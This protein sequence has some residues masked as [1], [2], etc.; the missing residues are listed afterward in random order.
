M[1]AKFH[2]LAVHDSRLLLDVR[3]NR[4]LPLLRRSS[5]V[6]EDGVLALY[7][8]GF[9]L[10]HEPP[11]ARFRG[12]EGGLVGRWGLDQLVGA[13]VKGWRLLP[14]IDLDVSALWVDAAVDFEHFLPFRCDLLLYADMI[15]FARLEWFEGLSSW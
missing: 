14:D 2:S 11:T 3:V 5:L 10:L 1:A 9:D 12:L 6:L 4:V 8:E 7:L 15:G 13:G